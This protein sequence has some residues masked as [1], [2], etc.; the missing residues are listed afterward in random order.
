MRRAD[1]SKDLVTRE[2]V[3][4]KQRTKS[5]DRQLAGQVTGGMPAHSIGNNEDRRLRENTILVSLTHLADV[6]GSSPLQRESH[7]RQPHNLDIS[8]KMRRLTSSRE[9]HCPNEV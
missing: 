7:C 5:M 6:C 2:V 1:H 3:A 9:L 8:L 4:T